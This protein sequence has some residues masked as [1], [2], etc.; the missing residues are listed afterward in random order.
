LNCPICKVEHTQNASVQQI[1]PDA[2][3]HTIDEVAKYFEEL[4]SPPNGYGNLFV[5]HD[6]RVFVRTMIAA[7]GINRHGW[8]T[9]PGYVKDNIATIKGVPLTFVMQTVKKDAG[10]EVDFPHPAIPDAHHK[11]N[12]NFQKAYTIGHY[13][14]YEPKPDPNG[15]WHGTA[16]V[17]HEKGKQF[18]TDLY[19]T[20]EMNVIPLYVS[21]QILHYNN[22]NPTDIKKWWFQHVT[23]TGDPAYP[24]HLSEIKDSC[25]GEEEVCISKLTKNSSNSPVKATFTFNNPDGTV[26]STTLLADSTNGNAQMQATVGNQEVKEQSASMTQIVDGDSCPKCVFEALNEI[27]KT[28]TEQKQEQTTTKDNSS[29]IAKSASSLQSKMSENPTTE[30]VATTGVTESSAPPTTT[31]TVPEGTATTEQRTGALTT[32]TQPK[33]PDA[34]EIADNAFKPETKTHESFSPEQLQALIQKSIHQYIESTKAA[35]TKPVEAPKVAE[36]KVEKV[37]EVKKQDK[38]VA[39]IPK[40]FQ[41][42]METLEKTNKKLA[43]AERR[44]KIEMT[45]L[46]FKDGKTF[47]GKDGQFDEARFKKHVDHWMKTDKEAEEVQT[48]LNTM[49]ELLGNLAEQPVENKTTE[50]K[51]KKEDEP[52]TRAYAGSSID[53]SAEAVY[54]VPQTGT[55]D[56]ETESASMGNILSDEPDFVRLERRIVL[57]SHEAGVVF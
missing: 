13:H 53:E 49:V 7:P 52:K 42:R 18:F 25:V 26:N 15:V 1:S 37:E 17:T 57:R 43:D 39:E 21:P 23:I 48:E 24:K 56:V 10:T 20:K 33:V 16:E 34:K 6:G 19:K 29:L 32:T 3:L 31:V 11:F 46:T 30:T 54:K 55:N 51:P 35:E 40:E 36:K 28:P 38:I 8:A 2:Q 44:R 45:L 14:T 27:V 41:E 12:E 9:S 47:T 4:P 5:N 50:T 22:E